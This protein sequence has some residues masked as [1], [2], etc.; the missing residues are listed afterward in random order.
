MDGRDVEPDL[1][2]H[3]DLAWLY[4]LLCDAHGLATPIHGA[5]SIYGCDAKERRASSLDRPHQPQRGST[6]HTAPLASAKESVCELNVRSFPRR[7][8][9][10]IRQKDLG[11]NATGALAYFSGAY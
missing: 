2:L 9:G 5:S 7:N 10:R 3:H 1:G 6:L 11:C 8:T 4:E